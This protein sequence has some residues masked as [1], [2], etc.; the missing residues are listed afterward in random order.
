MAKTKRETPLWLVLTQGCL[1]ALAVYFL[2]ALGL[3]SMLVNGR[4]GEGRV[5]PVMLLLGAGGAFLGGAV[6]VR[7]CVLSPLAAGLAVGGCF[8]GALCLAGAGCWREVTLL[9]RGGIQVAA[10]C[11]GGALGGVLV[12]K[13]RRKGKRVRR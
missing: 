6:S 5:L 12:G 9:G 4:V 13:R 11:A 10:I 7:R 1:L 3:T 8:A 2:G